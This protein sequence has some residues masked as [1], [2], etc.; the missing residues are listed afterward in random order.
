MV[1]TVAEF[2]DELRAL[3]DEMFENSE[4][5][6]LKLVASW[7]DRLAMSLE[8][9]SETLDMHDREIETLSESEA[10]EAPKMGE[11]CACPCCCEPMPAPKKAKPKKAK[12]AKPAKKKKRR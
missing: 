12:K 2:R 8:G 11:E 4:R 5:A 3:R 1:K 9:L 7:V 10:P 6:D